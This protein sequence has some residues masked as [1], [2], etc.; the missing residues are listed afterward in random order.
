MALEEGGVLGPYPPG[1]WESHL[2]SL[3]LTLL[4]MD[5]ACFPGPQRGIDGR[6][7]GIIIIAISIIIFTGSTVMK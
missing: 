6:A 1:A 5:K 3:G 2:S 7:A 4:P